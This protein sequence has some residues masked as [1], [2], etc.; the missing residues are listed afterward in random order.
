VIERTVGLH[1]IFYRFSRLAESGLLEDYSFGHRIY[2]SWPTA[3]HAARDYV[4]GTLIQS[5]RALPLI[6]SG[7]LTYYLQAKWLFVAAIAMLL[8]GLWLL[9]FRALFG[10]NKQRIGLM[11]LFLAI[12]LTGS[13]I[14]TNP[15]RS[16]AIVFM[17]VYTFWR[18]HA[19]HTSLIVTRAR[20]SAP[21]GEPRV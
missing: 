11:A 15:L 6:D 7:Y 12:Y 1:E 20:E 19:A 21:P 16:P 8:G 5:P 14:V 17:L 4:F 10:D 2:G 3:L 18:V 9:G 13:L